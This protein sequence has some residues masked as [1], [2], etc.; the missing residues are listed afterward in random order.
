MGNGEVKIVITQE[1]YQH[2]WKRAKERTASSYS[3]IH[4]GHYKSAAHSDYLSRTHALKLSLITA[5]GEAPE[6]WARGLSV[7][8][9]KIAGI[10]LVTKLR[11]ILLMEAD[12]NFHNKLIFGSRML[13]LARENG[14]IP[15]EIYNEKG[16]T[17]EDAILL[18]VLIYDLAYQWKRPLIVASV[19]AS[20]CYDRIAHAMAALVLRAYKVH[21]SSV[22]GML[23]PIGCME[24]YLRT[25]YGESKL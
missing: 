6:R 2:Y 18:Q 12:F 1:D 20:Q 8:L 9:E 11:A 13:K 14:M 16:R 15:E 7:M 3:G 21:A 19:D 24:F 23:N 10:A 25:G 22:K 17:A 4:Y 5:T